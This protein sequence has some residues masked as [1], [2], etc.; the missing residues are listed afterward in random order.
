MQ[1][2]RADQHSLERTVRQLQQQ[3]EAQRQLLGTSSQR[4]AAERERTAAA[5]GITTKEEAAM[6]V[7]SGEKKKI[8]AEWKASLL[9]MQRK[10]QAL[11]V[12]LCNPAL[13]A[14]YH[15]RSRPLGEAV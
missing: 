7:L 3:I 11:Q 12:Q 4:L 9:E 10:D 14:L 5:R 1:K 15:C 6:A 2:L 13:D 8:V